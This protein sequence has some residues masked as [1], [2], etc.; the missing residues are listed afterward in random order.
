MHG[1]IYAQSIYKT[2]NFQSV[3]LDEANTWADEGT[4]KVKYLVSAENFKHILYS[5]PLITMY[6]SMGV[7]FGETV[8]LN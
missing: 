5:D 8:P 4:L 6:S 3:L 2:Y 1:K 7:T